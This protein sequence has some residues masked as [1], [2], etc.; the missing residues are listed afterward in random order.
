MQAT[1]APTLRDLHTGLFPAAEPALPRS[2]RQKYAWI[3]EDPDL[4]P[5]PRPEVPLSAWS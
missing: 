5:A 4:A 2:R 3:D 1:R